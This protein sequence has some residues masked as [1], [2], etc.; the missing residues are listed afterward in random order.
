MGGYNDRQI[1]GVKNANE[2]RGHLSRMMTRR[3]KK[4]VLSREEP[5]YIKQIVNLSATQQE[6]YDIATDE[7]LLEYP[8]STLPASE[9]ANAM[10]RFM[11]LLQICATPFCISP[12]YP[13][14]SMKL[15][16]TVEIIAEFAA[17]NEKLVVFTGYRGVL[18]ALR[19]RLEKSNL[20][21]MFQ[22]HGDI[23]QPERVPIVKSWGRVTGAAVLG[24]MYQ[25]AGEGLN[26]VEASTVLRTDRLFVPGKN[27]QAVDRVDRIGQTQPVQVIDII[28]RGTVEQRV[29]SIIRG[30]DK[31]NQDIVENST[32]MAKL[33]EKL[34][35]HLEEESVNVPS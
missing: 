18:E 30:K 11:R 29:L 3:L 28:A 20:P 23:K 33:L 17:R 27:R 24:C 32:G 10:V 26:M 31:I 13:D 16:R 12:S 7:L 15:D 19:I 35:Q 8:G 5:D 25:V 21:P 9:I 34:R 6:M 22:I 4:D 2:L 1:T 14:D